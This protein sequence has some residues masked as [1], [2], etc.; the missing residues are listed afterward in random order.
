MVKL[1]LFNWGWWL[2]WDSGSGR[3]GPTPQKEDLSRQQM[4]YEVRLVDSLRKV[5]CFGASS[6]RAEVIHQCL[7]AR[8]SGARWARVPK[9]PNKKRK[10]IR[11]RQEAIL[12]YS[13]TFSVCWP[14]GQCTCPADHQGFGTW[15]GCRSWRHAQCRCDA[16][17]GCHAQLGEAQMVPTGLGGKVCKAGDSHPLF[18]FDLLLC[19]A[20]SFEGTKL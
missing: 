7:R 1:V 3:M 18:C 12:N 15:E 8:R 4:S 14:A 19:G 6:Q 10:S 9:M 17:C 11:S 13:S 2:W 20:S 5:S 16:Q